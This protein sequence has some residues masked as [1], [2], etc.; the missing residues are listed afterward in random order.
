QQVLKRFKRRLDWALGE[1]RRLGSSK[2]KKGDLDTED[3][4]H[5]RRCE[6]VIA[7]LKGTYER[8][9]SKAQGGPDDS[10]TMGALA[11]EGFLPGYGLESG[12]VV[13][14]AEPPRM[15]QG[16]DDFDLPRAPTLALRE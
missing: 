9:R 13:G 1:L 7:R 12:S 11:R 2:L 5:E 3:K 15:T 6:K 10:D 14:T 8:S 16:L 4:A